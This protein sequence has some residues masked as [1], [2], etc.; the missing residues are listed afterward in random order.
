MNI[1][2]DPDTDILNIV[3]RDDKIKESDEVSEGFIIDYGV[4]GGI[5]GFEVF[6]ARKHVTQPNAV[7]YEL[8]ELQA[9]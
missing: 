4:D 2:F 6:D 3:F 9:V 7:S 8:K 5:I 1:I